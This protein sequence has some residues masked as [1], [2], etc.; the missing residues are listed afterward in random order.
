[1]PAFPLSTA[2][3][4]VGL[5]SFVPAGLIWTLIRT[6]FKTRYHGTVGG[7]LWA[8][9]KPLAMFVVLLSVFSFVFVAEPAYRINL[10]LG[11]F[12]YEAF[13]EGTKSGLL[14]LFTKGYLLNKARFP[15]WIVVVTAGANALIS[16]SIFSVAL[17]AFLVSTGRPLGLPHLGL[18]LVYVVSL[19]LMATGISLASS[20]LFLKY[21]DLNQVWD[22]IIQA[23]FFLAPIIYP[24]GTIPERFHFYLYLWPPTPIIQ[25]SRAVL[26]EGSV[27]TLRAHWLLLLMTGVIFGAGLVLFRRLSPRAAEYL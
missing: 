16:L 4:P 5:R 24:L 1:M 22:V 23:G 27:P 12:L 15:S 2:A 11:I 21:R 8:L 13:S 19:V 17:I 26:I 6:D 20:V 18:Y 3:P 7:F 14:S 10:I 25:F 9:L